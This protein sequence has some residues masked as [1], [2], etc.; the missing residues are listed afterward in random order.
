M[1]LYTLCSLIQHRQANKK[2]D[3]QMIDSLLNVIE[4][5]ENQSLN[6]SKDLNT[7][8]LFVKEQFEK[9][10]Q[11]SITHFIEEIY[12][13]KLKPRKGWVNR[14]VMCPESIASHMYGALLLAYLH[15]PDQIEEEPE[16][17]KEKI[18]K[19]LLVHD[20]GE[21]YVGDWTPSEKRSKSFA[22]TASTSTSTTMTST[23][24]RKSPS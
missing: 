13:L 23:R 7:Y 14:N 8:I 3:P 12:Q 4:Q 24:V 16:Y 9:R 21:T 22:R 10:E 19:M 20:I 15:L 6:L 5:I 18:L 11:F 1:E 17:K 2:A